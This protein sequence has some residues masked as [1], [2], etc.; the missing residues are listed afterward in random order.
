M[1][2]HDFADEIAAQMKVN[3]SSPEHM[4]VFAASEKCAA[5]DCSPCECDKQSA[6]DS[7]EDTDSQSAKDSNDHFGSGEPKFDDS[8]KYSDSSDADDEVVVALNQAISGL[9]SASAALDAAGLVKSATLSLD[10]AQFVV[11]AKKKAKKKKKKSDS[12]KSDSKKS[13]SK[14]SD[15]KKSDSKKSTKK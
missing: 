11:E 14:K 8:S 1:T 5:C 4:S 13:D 12:K 9:L 2:K 6:K 15:S 10:L 7:K 3:L